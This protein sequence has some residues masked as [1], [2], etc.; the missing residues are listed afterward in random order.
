[1]TARSP[2]LVVPPDVD[3][4]QLGAY[5]LEG[6]PVPDG[7]VE[8]DFETFTAIGRVPD[9][10]CGMIQCVCEEARRHLPE[11]QRR[12]AITC[13]VEVTCGPHGLDVCPTCDPCGCGL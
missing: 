13:A 4:V 1:M 12:K 11:C 5:A 8:M 10:D 2:V 9:C 7:A 6:G 3:L